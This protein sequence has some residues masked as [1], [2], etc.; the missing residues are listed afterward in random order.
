[1]PPRV[2]YVIALTLHPLSLIRYCPREVG[3]VEAV[4]SV[5]PA[6]RK[7]EVELHLEDLRSLWT[8]K[9]GDTVI[10]SG[11]CQG[12]RSA[13]KSRD[14]S[15]DTQS[16]TQQQ[17]SVILRVDPIAESPCCRDLRCDGRY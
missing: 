4:T 17:H 3:V 15:A 2:A 9:H 5:L 12:L 8:T 10:D 7:P 13:A 16:I 6:L 11:P 14:Q 1:M